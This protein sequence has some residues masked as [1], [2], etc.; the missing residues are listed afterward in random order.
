MCCGSNIHRLSPKSMSLIRKLINGS[1]PTHLSVQ[2]QMDLPFLT[3]VFPHF[4]RKCLTLENP[5][6]ALDA[7]YFGWQTILFRSLCLYFPIRTLAQCLS[8]SS[9]SLQSNLVV[10]ARFI[11]YSVLIPSPPPDLALVTV[12]QF[13]KWHFVPQFY[14][15]I[16]NS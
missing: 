15:P 4:F 12:S 14:L 1:F 10:N 16:T 2:K 5:C 8:F 7:H 13:T 6:H 3:T 9:I 11:R